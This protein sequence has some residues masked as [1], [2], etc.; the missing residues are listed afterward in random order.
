[1]FPALLRLATSAKLAKSVSMPLEKELLGNW[2]E[3]RYA[4]VLRLFL[5]AARLCEPAV[6]L[7]GLRMTESDAS[8][9]TSAL[10]ATLSSGGNPNGVADVELRRHFLDLVT[11]LVSSGDGAVRAAFVSLGLSRSLA[12]MAASTD[13]AVAKKA[14]E[15]ASALRV[16]ITPRPSLADL[17]GLEVLGAIDIFARSDAQR[18]SAEVLLEAAALVARLWQ[19]SRSG[20]HSAPGFESVTVLIPALAKARARAGGA[21]DELVRRLAHAVAVVAGDLTL[22]CRPPGMY[23]RRNQSWRGGA[24]LPR[25]ASPARFLAPSVWARPPRCPPG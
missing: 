13:R 19:P 9:V 7:S 17:R 20:A 16:C 15:A 12:A 1:M 10:D 18:L 4:Q 3:P 21:A 6:F 24:L 14:R 8:R 23:M 2:S 5:A 22:E 11:H 25:A